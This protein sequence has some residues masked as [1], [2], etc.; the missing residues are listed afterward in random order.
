MNINEL[1]VKID[2][3]RL[4]HRQAKKAV[5]PQPQPSSKGRNSNL[6]FAGSLVLILG[7][8]SLQIFYSGIE[9]KKQILGSATRG[10]DFLSEGK[11]RL[12]QRN[13]QEAFGAFTDAAQTFDQASRQLSD[14]GEFF[15]LLL[16]NLP[17]GLD[18]DNF[19]EAGSHLSLAMANLSEGVKS[20]EGLRLVWDQTTNSSSL[21]FFQGLQKSHS[22]LVK[23][24]QELD[25]ASA[26]VAKINSALVPASYQGKF[27]SASRQL[28]EAHA[29]LQETT[30]WQGF[31]LNLLGGQSKT[32]ILIFQN[33]SEARA[34]G[35]FIGTYGILNFENGRMKIS[36][37]ES[38][39]AL[40]GQLRERI[41]AP[42]ALQ[43]Q[44]TPLWGMRDSNWFADFP[45]SSRKIISFF[46]K[47]SG[48]LADGVISFTPDVFE[49]LL[50]ITGPV[51]MPEYGETL[52]AQN[53]REVAQYKTSLDY[54]RQLNQ[55]KRFLADFAPRFL[56]RLQSLDE[57]QGRQVITVLLDLVSQKQILM[58]SLDPTLEHDIKAFGLAGEIKHT[59][60][61]YLAIIH[62]NVGGGKTDQDI[63]QTVQKQVRVSEAG[64]VRVD[65]AIIRSHHGFGE[66]FFPKNLDY[67]RVFVPAGSKLL[68]AAGFDDHEL[69]LSRGEN[70]VTDDDLLDQDAKLK[71]DEQNKMYIGEESGYAVFSN[72]LELSPGETKTVRLSYQLPEWLSS[73]NGSKQ[74][75][76]LLQKQSGARAFDFDLKVTLPTK[77]TYTF[78]DGFQAGDNSAS[79]REVVDSDRFYVVAGQ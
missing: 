37:I 36:R 41:A 52:A 30:A 34:T 60:G 25:A 8:G 35:G 75:R 15:D 49:K 26:S 19:L 20:L 64:Q 5:P 24:D 76:Q 6:F 54:D 73:L 71:R 29:L 68:A 50:E 21:D 55:P 1:E 57:N 45:S 51:A 12:A 79:A 2:G 62:S 17:L 32:Y 31:L 53:F 74:Y 40:D 28:Q 59:D 66:K 67:L 4:S 27:T 39:Y 18:V 70:A 42:G 65:L 11:D 61:D 72:W 58:D 23:S 14:S 63:E 46:E 44:E 47:E 22:S 78:P 77:I 10:L 43:R 16:R 56:A 33:N 48:L 13:Y 69:L 7:I 3:A 38:I 9:T